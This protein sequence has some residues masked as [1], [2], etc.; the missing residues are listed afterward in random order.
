MA[1]PFG[2]SLFWAS[3]LW[4]GVSD[5][6]D[7]PIARTLYAAIRKGAVIDSVSDLVFVI[8]AAYVFLSRLEVAPWMWACICLVAF[9]KVSNA[10]SGLMIHRKVIMLHTTA[11]SLRNSSAMQR[12]MP[13]APPVMT[14]ILSLYCIICL[15]A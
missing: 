4:C 14:T 1:V 9:T 10:V 2:G 13:C 12:P 3:Y 11:P 15:S 7:G 6:I 5:M 8:A